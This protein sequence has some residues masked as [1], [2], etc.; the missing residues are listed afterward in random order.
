[1]GLGFKVSGLGFK[2]SDF[3]FRVWPLVFRKKANKFKRGGA[4]ALANRSFYRERFFRRL[5]MKCHI[6][7]LTWSWSARFLL[8]LELKCGF[9]F[10]RNWSARFFVWLELKCRFFLGLEPQCSDLGLAAFFDSLE[11]E[12]GTGVRSEFGIPVPVKG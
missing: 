9:F 3:G 1:M 5:E 11:L 8:Q 6:I 4:A 7:F 2:V 10:T 12:C